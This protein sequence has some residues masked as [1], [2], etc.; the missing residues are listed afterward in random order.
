MPTHTKDYKKYMKGVLKDKRFLLKPAPRKN[1][2][3]LVFIPN[4]QCYSIHPSDNAINDIK[5]WIK[6]IQV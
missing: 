6:K 3:K 2:V 1:T 5:S 4:N